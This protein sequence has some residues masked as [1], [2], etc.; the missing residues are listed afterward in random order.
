M[1]FGPV[2]PQEAIGATAVHTIRQGTLVLKKGTLIGPVEAAALDA[3]GIK[4][5]VVARL[6][7]DDVSEDVAA[8]EIAAAI[9]GEGVHVDRAFTGRANLFAE[10]A[11][12]SSTRMPWIASTAS[13]KRSRLRPCPPT[14]RSFPAR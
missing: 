3:G 5:I 6:E 12:A 4:D 1:K 11:G 13:T 10:T 8:A 7:P 14:S 9:T 2:A